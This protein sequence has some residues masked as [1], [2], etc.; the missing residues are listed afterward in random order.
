MSR[1]TRMFD[2]KPGHIDEANTCVPCRS[3]RWTPRA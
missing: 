3:N 2:G 1:I